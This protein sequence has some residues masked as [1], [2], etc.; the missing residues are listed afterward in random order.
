MR[1]IGCDLHARQQTIA[2][3]DTETGE[4]VEKTLEHEG[5]EVRKF[6][7]A[8]PWPVL[9]GIEATG[10]MQW[11][12]QLMEELGIECRVGHPAKI[13]KAETRKQK[14]DRRD[15]RLLLTLLAE[16]RF[17][18]IWMP[19]AEQRDLRTLLRHRHQWVRMRSRVQHTLQSLALAHGLRRGHSLWS[20]VGQ[21]E[22]EGLPLARHAI[23]RRAA[24]LALYPRLQESIDELD[25]QVGEEARQRPQARRLL[26]HPGV[27]PVTAL[28]TEVF[29]GDAKRF[30]DGKAVASYI[31]MIPREHSSGRRQRLGA[32]SKEGNAL[33]R[34]LWCEAAMHAVGKDPELKRFYRR[35]LIQKGMGKARIAAARKLGIRL[36]IMLRDEIDYEEFCRRGQWRQEYGR[37]HAGM[38]D[39]NSGPAAS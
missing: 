26:T 2:M 36:W 24:L 31:G 23:Q 8:L 7:S 35:K 1:I 3:L 38:P 4:V 25:R 17:P 39:I 21:Q 30:P 5:D 20:Q 33:L 34:Y 9:V 6:Y 10:S 11:F 28:A 13:R 15:A 32:M 27:G 12:L 14:H 18:S 16:N 22:L 19:S 37:A 29:L